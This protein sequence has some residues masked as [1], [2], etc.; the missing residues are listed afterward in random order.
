MI[1]GKRW[2]RTFGVLCAAGAALAAATA[3]HAH[4]AVP[5]SLRLEL[6]TLE[7][8]RSCPSV[9]GLRA[10]IRVRLGYDPFGALAGPMV[11][12]TLDASRGG[13]QARIEHLGPMN[14]ELGE[15]VIHSRSRQCAAMVSAVA[16]SIAMAIGRQTE[17]TWGPRP[18][19][20]A[21]EARV[22]R[23]SLTRPYFLQLSDLVEGVP[24][25]SFSPF[26]RG[27]VGMGTGPGVSGGI[28]I[29][30]SFQRSGLRVGAGFRMSF[31]N[32]A[33]P[34]QG[35]SSQVVTACVRAQACWR[36]DEVAL[37][38]LGEGGV[39]R[40]SVSG[41]AGGGSPWAPQAGAGA[42]IEWAAWQGEKSSWAIAAE[43][44]G[45]LSPR[46]LVA[47]GGVVWRSPG[48]YGRVALVWRAVQR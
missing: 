12:V 39:A 46:T 29:G 33:L 44:L 43:V 45:D 11:R 10:A 7:G 36:G 28:G 23:R 38:I 9:D 17:R 16:L 37:C 6:I 4:G 8:A 14:E 41:L 5:A 31:S 32:S 21:S 48:A 42:G 27:T 24:R 20:A 35:S 19:P 47:D 34:G 2:L 22:A 15:R 40:A 26:I 13:V 18:R 25:G 3:G 1:G 30:M